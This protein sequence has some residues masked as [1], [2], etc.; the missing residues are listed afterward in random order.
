M[1]LRV[2]ILWDPIIRIGSQVYFKWGKDNTTYIL[3]PPFLHCQSTHN[4]FIYT[5]VCTYTLCS[6]V[7]SRLK[8]VTRWFG[9]ILSCVSLVAFLPGDCLGILHICNGP[10]F[11]SISVLGLK[12]GACFIMCWPSDVQKS[13]KSMVF[14]K[15]A[16]GRWPCSWPPWQR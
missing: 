13:P 2:P 7:S 5:L 3:S 15:G 8:F 16:P 12:I 10:W 11:S 14:R 1:S 4:L 6:P 9:S